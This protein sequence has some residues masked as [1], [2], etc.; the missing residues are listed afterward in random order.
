MFK[1][2]NPLNS[3]ALRL[4]AMF[5]LVALLVFSLWL[6]GSVHRLLDLAVNIIRGVP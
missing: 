2:P 4:S 1:Q 5:T 6:P 3:I